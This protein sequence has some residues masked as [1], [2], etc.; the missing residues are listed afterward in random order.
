[1]RRAQGNAELRLEAEA[2]ESYVVKVDTGE[3]TGYELAFEPYLFNKAEHL[4]TQQR[5]NPVS[6][7]V[8]HSES[9]RL[10][11][12]LHLDHNGT[13]ALSLPQAPFGGLQAVPGLSADTLDALLWTTE[14]W[15]IGNQLHR[16][17]IKTP[18]E[19]YDKK[20]AAILRTMYDRCHFTILHTHINHHIRITS[21]PFIDR[22]HPSERRRLRKCLRMGFSAE[23]WKDPDPAQLY[24]FLSESRRRQGY[25]LSLDYEQF[26]LLLTYLPDQ[27]RVVVI[28][29]KNQIVSLTVAIR[30]SSQILYNFCPADNL[31]YRTYS[32]MVL[33]NS[34]LYEHA[35][36]SGIKL[37]DLGVSLDHLGNEKA[38]LM[39]FKEN[40]GAE[41]SEKMTY[42][43]VFS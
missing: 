9:K 25:L 3:I 38:S 36:S 1:M 26:R 2:P 4:V 33:L 31:D 17:V 41:R 10:I 16:L 18:P 34:F 35:Q 32:P 5:Q 20:Q 8:W 28:K 29:D 11:A 23:L 42:E 24:D 12:L 13:E 6:I 22:I 30:V 27:V 14:Q 19:A 40:L 43:K 7:G 21:A 15:C 37:I 39:R